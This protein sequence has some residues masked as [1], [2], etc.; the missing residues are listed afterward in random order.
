MK[1]TII[2]LAAAGALA[3]AAVTAAPQPANAVAWWV[4]PAI[5]GGVIVGT[6]AGATV[7]NANYAR[8]EAGNVYV[9]P[10]G[11]YMARQRIDGV[12]HRVRVCN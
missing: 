1:K 12:W 7:A 11:C 4:A 10:T 5:I 8:A 2:S 6:A 3:A 9:R